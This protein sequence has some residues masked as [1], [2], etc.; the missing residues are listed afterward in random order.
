MHESVLLSETVELL[1]PR[2]GGRYVDG[3]I[4]GGGHAEAILEASSPD[5]RLLGLDLDAEAIARASKRLARFGE[6]VILQQDS[7]VDVERVARWER[8]APVDGILLD[9]GLSSDQLASTER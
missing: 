3:T 7:Y 5:G 9:L 1:R 4:G 6:R 8:F 2:S